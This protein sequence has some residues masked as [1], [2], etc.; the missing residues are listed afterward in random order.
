MSAGGCSSDS[1]PTGNRGRSHLELDVSGK[2]RHRRA[3]TGLRTSALEGGVWSGPLLAV[4][5]H[6]RHD[7][8]RQGGFEACCCKFRS[9][10]GQSFSLAQTDENCKLYFLHHFTLQ[11]GCPGAGPHMLL[12]LPSAG[13]GPTLASPGCWGCISRA[14]RGV[15]GEKRLLSWFPRGSCAG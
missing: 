9:G 3:G 14:V 8:G 12:E 11:P 6:P 7:P 13:S 15:P 5:P 10:S 2:R 4:T 1:L